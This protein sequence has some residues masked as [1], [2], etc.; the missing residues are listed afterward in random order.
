VYDD[1][2]ERFRIRLKAL[3][4]QRGWTQEKAA[5]NCGLG[6]KSFQLYELGIKRN[7]GLVTLAKIARGF[8]LDVSELLAPGMQTRRAG[9][10]K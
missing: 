5:E 7:P 9:L 2:S 3:R 8:S 4:L 1:I 6:Q 10:K